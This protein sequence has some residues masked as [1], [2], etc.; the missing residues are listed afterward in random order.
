MVAHRAF[1]RYYHGLPRSLA[2]DFLMAMPHINATAVIS[3]AAAI[4]TRFTDG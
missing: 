2:V 4:V 1:S 3:I